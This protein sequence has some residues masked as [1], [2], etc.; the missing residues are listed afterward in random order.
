MTFIIICMDQNSVSRALYIAPIAV[1]LS[2]IATA[3]IWIYFSLEW[4]RPNYHCVN[5]L[6]TVD[7]STVKCHSKNTNDALEVKCGYVIILTQLSDKRLVRL[8]VE[9]ELFKQWK[10]LRI[11]L[12]Q[13]NSSKLKAESSNQINTK[14]NL[15]MSIACSGHFSHRLV[16]VVSF[17]FRWFNIPNPSDKKISRKRFTFIPL[18]CSLS[19]SPIR[20]DCVSC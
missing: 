16:E 13:S 9:T 18:W 1:P 20:V 4:T 10:Y 5:H 8:L 3:R 12:C 2:S 19:I 6:H 11:Y 7:S 15:F 14:I 17:A